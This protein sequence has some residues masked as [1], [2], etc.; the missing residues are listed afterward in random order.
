MITMSIT[1]NKSF[2]AEETENGLSQRLKAYKRKKIKMNGRKNHDLRIKAKNIF[3]EKISEHMFIEAIYKMQEHK[4][5]AR[6]N[7]MLL[8]LDIK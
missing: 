3:I 1:E 6:K 7:R 4:T 8:R 5:R 2:R